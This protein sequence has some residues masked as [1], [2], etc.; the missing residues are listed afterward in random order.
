MSGLLLLT[1]AVLAQSLSLPPQLDLISHPSDNIAIPNGSSSFSTVQ[2]LTVRPIIRCDVR[3]GIFTTPE[4]C[5][6]AYRKIPV[7]AHD[8]NFVFRG[9]GHGPDDEFV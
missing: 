5:N 2:N 4:A 3:Y 9:V 7:Y 6:D 8:Q 1:L